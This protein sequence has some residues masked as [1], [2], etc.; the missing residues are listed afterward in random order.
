MAV[1]IAVPRLGWNME[2]G[3]FAGWLK[4]AGEP[5]KERDALFRLESDK[6]TEEVES[7][8]GGVLWVA[9]DGPSE[10]D[11]LAVGTV[12]GYLLQAGEA[13]PSERTAPQP[14]D[15][16]PAIS[17]RAR[18]VAAELGIDWSRLRGSGRTGRIRE[19]DVREA[20]RT[21]SAHGPDAN[22]NPPSRFEVVPVTPLRQVIAE[23][24]LTS[25]RST[26]PVTLTTSADA[27]NLVSLRNQFKAVASGADEVVP[28]Y[29]D[30]L[31]KLAASALERHPTL[32]SQWAG[33]QLVVPRSIHIGIAVDTD[34]GLLVPVIRDAARLTL[35]QVAMSSRDLAERARRGQLRAEEMQG[36]TFTV[37]NLG[38]FGVEAFTPIINY[39]QCSILGVGR[40]QRQP[41]AVGDRIVACDRVTLSLTF[42]HRIVDGGP[43]A[44]FLQTLC[45]LV[46][47]P[48][49]C[50]V[51]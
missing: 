8:G 9:P 18:R 13:P 5:V 7:P 45:R 47:N 15:D 50:L 19:R 32:N 23:R 3:V 43:A 16:A 33:G 42:D 20:A 2:E 27:T 36:G 17:P 49:P 22:P 31:V 44:R 12:I 37:T 29:T 39:P 34:A 46:E 26:A 1:A 14:I 51:R 11:R 28:G 38:A 21:A 41:L 35:R 4:K 48:G 25:L 30:F 24:M 6:A 40:I 10:G